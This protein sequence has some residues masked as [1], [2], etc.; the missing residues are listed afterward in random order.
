M[1]ISLRT[2]VHTHIQIATR[3][4][5][6]PDS[7]LSRK[8]DRHTADAVMKKMWPIVFGSGMGLGMAYS[9]CW[10]DFQAPYL[11]HGKFVREQE[12]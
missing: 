1:A 11:L 9:K 3:V 7:E 10:H 6:I 5:N 4:G 12:Q 2:S 8:W